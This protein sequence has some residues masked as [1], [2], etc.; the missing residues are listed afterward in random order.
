MP[1]LKIIY[2]SGKNVAEEC[3]CC[4]EN[5]NKFQDYGC[6]HK[7]C[8]DCHNTMKIQFNRNTCLY[9]DPLM[10]NTVTIN[11]SPRVE[12]TDTIT[13][14]EE[15]AKARKFC[16]D[17]FC[18]VICFYSFLPLGFIFR[19]VLYNLDKKKD[20]DVFDFNKFTLGKS[21]VGI[22]YILVLLYILATI[23]T[24]ID[25]IRLRLN[26]ITIRDNEETPTC[27]SIVFIINVTFNVYNKFR[28]FICCIN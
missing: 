17:F 23:L 16:I 27:K 6:Q 3:I 12:P 21:I 7:I 11:V 5:K 18:Y 1:D 9:C 15:S 4:F 22:F 25:I 2:V 14:N 20:V 26:C 24:I 10:T 13:I 28:K 19:N 8:T